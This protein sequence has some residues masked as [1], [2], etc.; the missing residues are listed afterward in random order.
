I[1]CCPHTFAPSPPY[2][3][4]SIFL[5]MTQLPPTSTLFPYTT[6]FRSIALTEKSN[7]A[8]DDHAQN[9]VD[10]IKGNETKLR[11]SV[12]QGA[13]SAVNAHMGNIAFKT[14]EKIYWDSKTNQFKDNAS[15]NE[16]VK[17]HYHNGWELPKI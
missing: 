14:G 7:E 12:E 9:F 11:C 2:H 8:L 6:L 16:L 17:A 10:V 15:A 5:F 3:L 4:H 13:I 1:A